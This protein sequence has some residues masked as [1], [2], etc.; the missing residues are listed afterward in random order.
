MKAVVVSALVPDIR[1]IYDIY[2]AAFENEKMA[3]LMLQILFP[4]GITE[5]FRTAH[6]ANT[7][8]F[9]NICS[10]Q[11]TMKCLDIESGEIVGMLLGDMYVKPRTPEERQNFGV[12]W[13]EGAERERAEKV[14]NP[15][16]EIKEKL[17]G[18]QPYI[19]KL[20]PI[21]L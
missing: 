18:G 5:E 8:A 13:L 19:C 3:Q 7:L 21:F 15:L 9:W 17:W 10:Y 4:G 6:T 14:L 20:S 1:K 12:P 16:W 2:F 11:Y